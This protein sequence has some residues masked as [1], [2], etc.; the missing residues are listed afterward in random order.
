MVKLS[1]WSELELLYGG[2][3][4]AVWFGWV[5]VVVWCVCGL[6]GCLKLVLESTCLGGVVDVNMRMSCD[7]YWVVRCEPSGVRVP[8]V[9]V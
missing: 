2:W 3:M 6:W 5:V 9:C 7:G 1:T 4:D 8:W